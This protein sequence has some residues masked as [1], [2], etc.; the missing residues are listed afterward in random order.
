VA[1]PH[2]LFSSSSSNP[3]ILH[4]FSIQRS[5]TVAS[6]WAS[7]TAT[8]TVQANSGLKGQMAQQ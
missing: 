6:P 4:L 8:A 5:T 2:S 1:P 7:T 3:A